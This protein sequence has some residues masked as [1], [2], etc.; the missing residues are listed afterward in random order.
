MRLSLP[1]KRAE[2]EGDDHEATS[3]CRNS[4]SREIKEIYKAH[5]LD[6]CTDE[7]R[8]EQSDRE[9]VHTLEAHDLSQDQPWIPYQSSV[10]H[11]QSISIW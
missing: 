9:V 2:Q 11:L 1:R 10:E 5:V 4:Q 7:Y 3:H 6:T 8:H